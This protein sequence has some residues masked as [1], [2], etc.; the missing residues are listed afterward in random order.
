MKKIK[1]ILIIIFTIFIVT[2]TLSNNSNTVTVNTTATTVEQPI[3]VSVFLFDFTDDFI[4]LIGKDLEEI[5][6]QNPDKV[7]YT[8]YDGKTNQAIQT[9]SIDKVLNEGSADLILLNIV[10]VGASKG[11]IN[12][13]KQSNLPVIFF[14][15]EPTTLLPIQSYN[16]AIYI[17]TDSKITG[18]IQGKMLVDLWNSSKKYIDRNKD[19]VM[20]YFLLQGEATNKDAIERTKYSIS[21]IEAAGIETEQIAFENAN[22]LED[23]AYTVTKKTFTKY[24]K[25]IEV[26]NSNDDTM[27]IGAVKALQEFEYN[28][29]NK[30]RTIPIIGVDVTPTA[31]E[32]IEKG[33]MLGSVYQSS[34]AYADALYLCGINLVT[35]KSSIE[36]TNYKFDDSLVAIRITQIDYLYNNIFK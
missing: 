2:T 24:N 21:T 20:Q 19:N 14:Q 25:Q 1:R 16:K 17:G 5:Q 9:A 10:D 8:F 30:L 26:I 4:S 15:R 11:I 28:T 7:Q 34:K 33:Y 18:I 6:K 29:G 32:Y 27:A 13:I 35:G 36:G 12:K 22:W 31:K 3:R 23:L